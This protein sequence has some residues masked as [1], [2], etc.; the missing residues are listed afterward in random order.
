M[1]RLVHYAASVLGGT[2]LVPV[3]GV[4]DFHHCRAVRVQ[5]GN[6][7]FFVKEMEPDYLSTM[8]GERRQAAAHAIAN[9]MRTYAD[10]FK[11]TDRPAF[12]HTGVDDE[13]SVYEIAS[14]V[15]D[16]LLIALSRS[17]HPETLIRR[18]IE[19]ITR[20]LD[21]ADMGID[22]HPG[23]FGVCGD[24]RVVYLD[25]FPAR[26][27]EN[28]VPLV[29][30][31]QPDD[32]TWVEY[33]A[34]RYYT[35]FGVMRLLRFNLMRLNPAYEALFTE[36]AADV[37]GTGWSALAD[38]FY[39]LPEQRVLEI[40]QAGGPRDEL[41]GIIS[42]LSILHIDTAREVAARI[43]HE[44]IAKLNQLFELTHTDFRLPIAERE[45]RLRQFKERLTSYAR[46]MEL[47][48]YPTS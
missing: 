18:M 1:D 23:N 12:Y 21:A 33:S 26:Y 42:E 20:T 19:L 32:P 39:E 24:G 40:L 27:R 9:N 30:F 17:H 36:V 38:Q 35:L 44:D 4:Q 3:H 46:R 14:F 48:P 31:P 34:Q 13:L 29:G 7:S 37:L 43:L 8:D 2:Q 28:G 6:G 16:D 5:N 45:S 41:L 10:L 22:P 47:T 11:P 15:G 25:F